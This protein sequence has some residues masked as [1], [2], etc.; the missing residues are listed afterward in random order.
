VVSPGVE[1]LLDFEHILR[2]VDCELAGWRDGRKNPNYVGAPQFEPSYTWPTARR[3]AEAD[4]DDPYEAGFAMAHWID[5]L[6][7]S[8]SHPGGSGGWPVCWNRP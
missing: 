8:G 2:V 6:L 7:S 1:A 5:L 4:P 3:T